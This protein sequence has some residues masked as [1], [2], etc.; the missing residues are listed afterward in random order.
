[1]QSKA[2]K[3]ILGILVALVLIAGSFS[4]GVAVGYI[5]PKN[6]ATS[7]YNPSSQ[8]TTPAASST[9]G[10][11]TA[12]LSLP[13]LFK[14]FWQAWDLVHQ[15]YVNQ[16]V[17]DLNMMRGAIRGMLASLGDA[18][19]SYMN[20]EEFR[21]ANTP[22]V[23]D[24]EGIGAYVDITGAFL[25]ITSPMPGSPAEKAGLKTGDKIVAV[26]G[27]DVT[28]LDGN[29]VLQKVLGPAGSTVKL[30][31]QRS[32]EKPFDVDIVRAKIVLASV[33]GKILDGGIAYV[34]ITT[35][36]DKTMT[37]LTDTL[38]QVMDQKPK[39]LILDLRN[40]GGGYLVTAIDVIS[41]FVKG[42]QTV[43]FEQSGNG[44]KKTYT[45]KSGGL[46]TDI[47][48][49]ILV[50][51]GSASASEITAGAMQDLSRAKLVGVTTYGKGSVQNWITLD[52]NQG[53]VRIT[54]AHWLTPNG[55]LIDKIGLIPDVVVKMTEADLK[56]KLDPQLDKAVEVLKLIIGK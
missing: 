5:V 15:E 12:T 4:G 2:L 21:Q 53:A 16:P 22:L 13:E 11:P 30:T 49:V 48:M 8:I 20:P 24:Y 42:G 7:I 23:G 36:G 1:M 52:G 40:N 45:S 55:H 38:K 39:G 54:I 51:E 34:D 17:N 29:L 44:T 46:A 6:G 33:T 35:F 43:M 18:H 25:T 32:E 50:N 19:T 14:P 9:S 37:E 41:Q 27:A 47:P 26:D 3:I 31:I 56:A 28:G 10:T